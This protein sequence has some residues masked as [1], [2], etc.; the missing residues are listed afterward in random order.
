MISGV[1]HLTLTQREVVE[2]ALICHA[3][4][5]FA[6]MLADGSPMF[7]GLVD[8]DGLRIAAQRLT[9]ES[10]VEERDAKLLE[11]LSLH[12]SAAAFLC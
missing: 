6:R 8:A 12:M 2:H 5:I 10:Y 1:P 3:P 7:D 9:T 4:G 11:V